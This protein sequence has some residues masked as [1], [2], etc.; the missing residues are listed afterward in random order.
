MDYPDKTTD[1]LQ[2]TDKPFYIMLYRVHFAKSGIRIH[3]FSGDRLIVYPTT[4]TITIDSGI[5]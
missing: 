5:L 1:L 4:N 2:V 3:N